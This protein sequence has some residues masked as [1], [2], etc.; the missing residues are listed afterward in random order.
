MLLDREEIKP[1]ISCTCPVQSMNGFVQEAE[2]SE[3]LLERMATRGRR[4]AGQA[5]KTASVWLAFPGSEIGFEMGIVNPPGAI[6]RGAVCSGPPLTLQSK[7]ACQVKGIYFC[8]H[9]SGS[10]SA[11][12]AH[13][14]HN[15]T[16]YLG[17]D[18]LCFLQKQNSEPTSKPLA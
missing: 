8:L 5:Q 10:L 13:S 15:L 12:L 9:N 18:C 16:G 4:S 3:L 17:F 11:Q 2:G 14:Q 6:R 1:A 7:L